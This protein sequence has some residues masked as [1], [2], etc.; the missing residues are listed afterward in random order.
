MTKRG[1]YVCFIMLI[2]GI[3]LGA[4]FLSVVHKPKIVY[5]TE[6]DTVTITNTIKVDNFIHDTVTEIAYK[7]KYFPI[8][9][10]TNQVVDTNFVEVPIEYHHYSKPDT[11]DIYYHGYEAAL[12][13]VLIYSKTQF[14]TTINYIEP[15]K[16]LIQLN[17]S[18][19]SSSVSYSRRVNNFFLGG[20]VGFNYQKQPEVSLHVGYSF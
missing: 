7:I 12:D 15:A 13:S 4:C 11:C 20:G 9:D 2:A 16:N 8:V 14:I 17:V 10:S 6:H 1:W 5:Q 18:N 3:I 19:F